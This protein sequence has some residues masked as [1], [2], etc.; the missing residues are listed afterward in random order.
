MFACSCAH[1][2][3]TRILVLGN[4]GGG[5]VGT[6]MRGSKDAVCWAYVRLKRRYVSTPSLVCKRFLYVE[7]KFV[8]S[9]VS[10]NSGYTYPR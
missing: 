7:C 4:G 5:A 3:L 2:L 10:I 9:S 8:D 1:S 6:A